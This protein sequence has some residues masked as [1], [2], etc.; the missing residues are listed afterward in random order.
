MV[1]ELQLKKSDFV[2]LYD[3]IWEADDPSPAQPGCQ[4]A[5]SFWPGGLGKCLNCPEVQLL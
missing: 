2:F 1:R 3:Y 5:Q 4:Q